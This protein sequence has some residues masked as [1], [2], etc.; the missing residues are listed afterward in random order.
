[1]VVIHF[2]FALFGT[3]NIFVH[4]DVSINKALR[5]LYD[6]ENQETQ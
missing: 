3:E 4:G 1:M 5:S 2:C 6:L